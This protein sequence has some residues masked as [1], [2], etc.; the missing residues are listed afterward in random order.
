M[1]KELRVYKPGTNGSAVKFQTRVDKKRY[2]ELMCFAEFANQSGKSAD[3]FAK[4]DWKSE[5]NP[6]SKAITFKFSELDIARM[7][8]V[9]RG[10]ADATEIY[11]DPGKSYEESD[12]TKRS[13]VLKIKK[14]DKGFLMNISNKVGS[15]LKSV[16]ISVSWEEGVLLQAF[17]DNFLQRFYS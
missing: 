16:G 2:D 13:T 1:S 11:H 6:S 3:G 10:E 9:L 5:D 4:F 15:E 7:L 8:L 14:G 12:N 17:C